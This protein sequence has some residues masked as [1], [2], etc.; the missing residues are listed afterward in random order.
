MHSHYTEKLDV[1]AVIV[2]FEKVLSEKF[3]AKMN[4]VSITPADAITAYHQM[5]SP[6]KAAELCALRAGLKPCS[7]HD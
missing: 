4:E 5:G 3:H 6:A 1:H 2:E 7:A